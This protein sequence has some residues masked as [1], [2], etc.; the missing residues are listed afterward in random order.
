MKVL[1]LVQ[2]RTLSNLDA[3]SKQSKETKKGHQALHSTGMSPTVAK[4]AISE[5][6]KNLPHQRPKPR[7]AKNSPSR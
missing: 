7:E 1:C 5:K 3:R 4:K 2:Y 6:E